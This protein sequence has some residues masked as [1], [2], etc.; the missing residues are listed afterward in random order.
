MAD[1]PTKPPDKPE[2][3]AKMQILRGRV[4]FRVGQ[5]IILLQQIEAAL[6]ALLNHASLQGA[7]EEEL[8]ENLKTRSRSTEHQ[9]LGELASKYVRRMKDPLDAAINPSQPAPYF[10]IRRNINITRYQAGSAKLPELVQVGP[11]LVSND[12]GND[13][14]LR[15]ELRR[16]VKVRNELVHHLL[17]RLR[18]RT[19]KTLTEAIEYLTQLRKELLPVFERLRVNVLALVEGDKVLADFI[20]SGHWEEPIQQAQLQ[21]DF[22]NL[23]LHVASEHARP[24]GW[25]YLRRASQVAQFVADDEMKADAGRSIHARLKRVLAESDLFDSRMEPGADGLSFVLYRVKDDSK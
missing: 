23:L 17:P 2:P 15:R 7:S 22:E 20:N 16:V 10:S 18:P 6:K 4:S 13:V 11:I 8:D 3:E 1:T 12:S 21:H 9:T 5:N 25:T 14:N 24:D 19:A